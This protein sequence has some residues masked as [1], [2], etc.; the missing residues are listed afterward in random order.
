MNT[1]KLDF[2]RAACTAYENMKRN[3]AG[4]RLK[5]QVAV[6]LALPLTDFLAGSFAWELFKEHASRPKS[7]ILCGIGVGH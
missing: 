7:Y 3:A 6:L 4:K 2:I 1:F 5:F